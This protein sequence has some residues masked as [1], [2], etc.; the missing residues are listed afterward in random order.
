MTLQCSSHVVE[1]A[2]AKRCRSAT[3]G[4]MPCSFPHA[5]PGQSIGMSAFGSGASRGGACIAGP[6]SAAS[7]GGASGAAKE[8]SDRKMPR[9]LGRAT[10]RAPADTD[11][12]TVAT[13]A[14]GSGVAELAGQAWAADESWNLVF[15]VTTSGRE[16]PRLWK[17]TLT[18]VIAASGWVGPEEVEG[19]PA[20][21][22]APAAAEAR[23]VGAEARF[24]SL[25]GGTAKGGTAH[26]STSYPQQ[27]LTS[28]M[29]DHALPP[30]A[31]GVTSMYKLFRHSF[32][33]PPS[34][35]KGSR[36]RA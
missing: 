26:T 24:P 9:A 5:R 30:T 18:E 25:R 23:R 28:R 8:W 10:R 2:P 33:F 21:Y 14:P 20:R 22:R 6:A 17:Q 34:A 27:S 4:L 13:G 32:P 1:A 16:H 29:V 7:E 36:R 12:K 35:I 11:A 15:L 19:A 31:C 3:P